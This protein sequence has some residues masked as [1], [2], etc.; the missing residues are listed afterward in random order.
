MRGLT[1]ENSSQIFSSKFDS[2]FEETDLNI[3]SYNYNVF[4]QSYLK[5]KIIDFWLGLQQAQLWIPY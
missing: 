2:S 5:R 1:T 3:F 4:V